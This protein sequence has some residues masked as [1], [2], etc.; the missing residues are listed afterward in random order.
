MLKK[1]VLFISSYEIV[2]NPR[3]VKAA[4][5]L[6]EKGWDIH[7]LTP[8]VG[9]VNR[10]TYINFIK[11]RDWNVIEID[12]SKRTLKSKIRWAFA[13]IS[14]KIHQLM[15]EK[16]MIET[17][18]MQLLNKSLYVSNSNKTPKVDVIYINLVDNLKYASLLK[19]KQ[20][21]TIFVFDSQEYFT[22]QYANDKT[23]KGAWINKIEHDYIKHADII[24][25]TTTA[26]KKAIEKKYAIENVIRLRNLPF[27][28][29]AKYPEEKSKPNSLSVIWHGLSIN[30]NSRGI[31]VIIE[32]LSKTKNP[33]HLTLQ[34]N[35]N[36]IQ[37]Q[38]IDA[39]IEKLNIKNRITIIEPAHP[40]YIVESLLTYDVGIIA[41]LPLEDNQRLTSSN[42]LFEYIQAGLCVVSSNMPG[43]IETIDEYNVGC[44]YDAGNADQLAEQLDEL[45]D[46]QTKL[47]GFK[48]Q[49]Q[50]VAK[51]LIWKVDFDI[52]HE[53]ITSLIE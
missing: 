25:S 15:F 28:R 3:L 21:A 47:L 23:F 35:I 9:L 42:K 27:K 14:Q 11:T 49:S 46:N 7:I 50:L 22:G 19:Q 36:S 43:I 37:K 1:S 16:L 33:V 39:E 30:Y 32:A 31:S 17:K 26:M 48:K 41:E 45:F 29:V 2:Y 44:I 20:P 13:S 51:E 38:L 12:I 4:D 18:Q 24:C 10:E 40:D 6:H 52:V 34:G 8:V 5:Y 53:K